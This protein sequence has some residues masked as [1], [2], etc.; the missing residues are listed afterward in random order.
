M[1]FKQIELPTLGVVRLYKRRDARSIKIT[2]SN[3]DYVRVTLPS[4]APYKVGIEY[5][6]SKQD[7]ISE[8]RRGHQIIG[9]GNQIGKSHRISLL[10]VANAQTISTRISGTTITVTYPPELPTS[11]QRLQKVLRQASTRALSKEAKKLLPQRTKQLANKYNFVYRNL[12]IRQ[13]RSRWGSCSTQKDIVLSQ[14]LML[15]PWELIDYVILHELTHT[16][17][18]NHSKQFWAMLEGC[19]PNAKTLRRQLRTFQ[20]SL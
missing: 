20:P 7:W 17:F 14:H 9:H 18:L 19:L 11:D 12:K 8:H 5:A 2:L 16:K 1:A 13:L 10:A 4:W 15:L 6:K 3:S